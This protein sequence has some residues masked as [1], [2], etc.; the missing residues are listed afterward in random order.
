MAIEKSDTGRSG[1]AVI[2]SAG[3]M[4]ASLN[5]DYVLSLLL[6]KSVSGL[7][8]SAGNSRLLPSCPLPAQKNLIA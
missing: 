6:M 1:T 5:K 7:H 4:G 2:S 3:G 8:P